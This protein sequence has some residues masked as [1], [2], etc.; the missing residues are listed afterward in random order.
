[1]ITVYTEIKAM[2]G[3]MRV[4]RIKFITEM[5]KRDMTVKDLAEKSEISR[6]T[7]S[8]L[9]SGKKCS[10]KT[11][12]ALAHAMGVPVADLIEQEG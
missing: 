2:E 6:V 1:M 12:Y 7:I 4:D 8:A 10:N 3:V 5:A 11:V 9:R